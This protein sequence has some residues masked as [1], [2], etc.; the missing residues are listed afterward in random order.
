MVVVLV[1]LYLV[2]RWFLDYWRIGLAVVVGG[3]ALVLLVSSLRD[4]WRR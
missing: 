2:G 3:T 1:L 4:I